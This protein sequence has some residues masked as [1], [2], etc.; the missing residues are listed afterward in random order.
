MTDTDF[1][2]LPSPQEETLHWTERFLFGI[3]VATTVLTLLLG[4]Q[5]YEMLHR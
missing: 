2:S 4:L 3:V 1:D 5:L